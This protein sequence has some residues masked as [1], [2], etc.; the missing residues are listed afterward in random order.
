MKKLIVAVLALLLVIP[1]AFAGNYKNRVTEIDNFD[2]YAWVRGNLQN[3]IYLFTVNGGER[4][5]VVIYAS[6]EANYQRLVEKANELKST[7]PEMN[8]GYGTPFSIVRYV[9]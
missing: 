4:G 5:R 2:G 6:S 9:E 1:F 8:V 7:K 3:E